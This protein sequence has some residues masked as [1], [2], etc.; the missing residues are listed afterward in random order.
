MADIDVEN[1]AP[2]KPEVSQDDKLWALLGYIVPVIALLALLLEEKKERPFVR[3]HAVQALILGVITIVASA[4]VCG[5]ILVWIYAIYV[6]IRAY[7]GEWVEI[8]FFTDF[9]RQQGWIE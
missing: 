7:Q 4:T 1:V 8:P 3:Y 5:W 9:A 2:G 6:G